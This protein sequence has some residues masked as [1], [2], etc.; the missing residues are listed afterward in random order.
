[1]NNNIL[2]ELLFSYTD[3]EN[4]Y[5]ENSDYISSR[6]KDIDKIDVN[7]E[8]LYLFAFNKFL[9]QSK[10]Y[11]HKESR[12]TKIPKHI[13]KVIEIN[14]VYSGSCTQII[15]EQEVKLH[16]GDVCILDTDVPHEILPL[17]DNDIVIDIVVEKNYFTYGLLTRLSEQGV[18]SSF[19]SN[20]IREDKNHNSYV[21][22]INS[23]N[24]N[25]HRLMQGL[26]C[27]YF[28]KQICSNQIIDSYMVI[29]FSELLRTLIT[30][31][32]NINNKS[33]QNKTLI[34]IL[35]FLEKNYRYCTLKSV[36]ENFNF[37]PN[38]L[39]SYLK[40][41]TGNT[42]KEL[43]ITQRMTQA[44]LYLLNTQAPIYEIANKVGYENLGFFYKKFKAFYGINPHEYRKLKSNKF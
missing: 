36:A 22:F 1:M 28:H 13:H 4:A 30:N 42:F 6:Y 27:E 25:L 44:S 33:D 17:N 16:Q 34:D 21:L 10:I 19:L 31:E 3:S 38:Y 39:S 5:L 20:M 40:Q 15:N 8:S 37:H 41:R 35:Q 43:L 14:Y 2:E 7:N 23:G 32:T 29:I 18:L 12:F 9:S 11:I 24:E 26:L